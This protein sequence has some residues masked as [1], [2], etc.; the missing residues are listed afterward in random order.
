[1]TSE[2]HVIVEAEGPAFVV[3]LVSST[4]YRWPARVFAA[5]Q[6][7]LHCFRAYAKELLLTEI[8]KGLRGQGDWER[9]ELWEEWPKGGVLGQRERV[10]VA[11]AERGQIA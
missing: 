4:G 5:V 9:V 3:I 8:R 10:R 6:E 1:M 11:A 2:P 7:G